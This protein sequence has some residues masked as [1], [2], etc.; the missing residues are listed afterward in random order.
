ML[1]QNP[2]SHVLSSIQYLTIWTIVLVV[3]HKWTHKYIN[4]L[5]LTSTVFIFAAYISY[6]RPG[7][8]KYNPIGDDD[9]TVYRI[10]GTAKIVLDIVAHVLPLLFVMWR[11]LPYYTQH[12]VVYSFATS[13]AFLVLLIYLVAFDAR[14]VYDAH[15]PSTVVLTVMCLCAYIILGSHCV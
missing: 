2:Q 8:F 7:Y 14:E 10:T 4:L 11:Y 9:A 12:D 5:F 6:V 1:L 13:N 15:G 3:F